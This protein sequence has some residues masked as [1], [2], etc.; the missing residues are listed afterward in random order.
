A[1]AI[2]DQYELEDR[3]A[4]LIGAFAVAGLAAVFLVAAG[5]WFL[6]RRSTSPIEANFANMRRFM[7]DA[8]HQL[9]TPVAILQAN[10][11]VLLQREREPAEYIEGLKRTA[12]ESMRLGILVDRMLMLARA[13]AGAAVT[14]KRAVFLDDIASDCIAG[15]QPMAARKGVGIDVRSFKEAPIHADPVLIRELVM[16]L[17]D[18][19][20]KYT[21]PGGT[22]TVRIEMIAGRPAIDISDTGPG[23][24]PEDLQKVFDRF[25]RGELIRS[26]QDGAG[27]GL[28][29]AK[30]IADEH[31]AQIA[32]ESPHQRGTVVAV[33][34]P[35]IV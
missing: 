4:A 14:S 11:D 34:F 29:I 7:A 16:I 20:I 23:I 3:Y 28:S 22:V 12:E 18:N 6:A 25:F 1:A 21:P 2:A 15:A 32:I 30:W 19:A 10:A 27:L 8:A 26:E 24:R 33:T 31:G 13:D 35:A 9:K 5:G 17:L